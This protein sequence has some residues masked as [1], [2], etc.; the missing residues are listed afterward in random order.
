M[1]LIPFPNVPDVPGVPPIPR[2]PGVSVAANAGLAILQ[3]AIWR[4][5][6]V[7]SQWGIFNAANQPLG[8]P[9]QITGF[10]GGLAE[11]AGFLLGTTLSTGSVTYSK[12]TKVSD[13][14][15]EKGGFA[16]YN[17]VEVPGMPVVTLCFTGS[18]SERTQFLTQIDTACKSTEL[19]TVVTPE[20]QYPQHSIERY[21]YQRRSSG[22]AT[23]LMVEMTLKEIREVTA[24]YSQSQRQAQA[25]IKDPGA[26]SPVDTGKVQPSV[27]PT[28]TV[29]RLANKLGLNF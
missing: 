4:Y 18:E 7:E 1:S 12:E 19:Y 2:L 14:P 6:S 3:G 15:V 22:G 17:K 13:F 24:A 21:S 26:A 5:F 28:S 8:D 23:L 20:I 10:L 25:S 16:S 27:S 11:S 9:R 29:L